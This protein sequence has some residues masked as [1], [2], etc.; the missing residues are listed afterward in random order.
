MFGKKRMRTLSVDIGGSHVKASVLSARGTMIHDRVRAETP[1]DL[2]PARL[3]KIIVDLAEQL[4]RYDR[5][6]VGFPGVVRSGVILTAA[7]L[8]DER[9]ARFNLGRALTRALGTP[10]RVCNDAD[11]QGFG[12]I[13]GVGVEMVITLGTGFGSSLFEDGRL[14]PHLELAHHPFHH[15]RTYEDELSDAAFEQVGSRVWNRRLSLAIDTLRALTW[16]DHLYIGGGN[17]RHVRLKL[18]KDISVVDNK[19]GIIGGIR[20]W[21]GEKA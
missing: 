10:V 21:A 1:D 9:F 17:S 5:V 14:G 8:G 19:A 20:L 11:M 6:S 7:N 12:A 16:F 2:T 3:V 4:P 15:D 13:K 18:P